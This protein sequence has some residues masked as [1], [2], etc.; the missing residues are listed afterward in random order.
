MT[1]K[2]AGFLATLLVCFSAWAQPTFT[3]AA[4]DVQLFKPGP[5]VSDVLNLQGSRVAEPFAWQA[6]LFIHYARNPLI[7]RNPVTNAPVSRLVGSQTAFDL[8][9]SVG[10]AKNFELG[11]HLPLTLQGSEPAPFLGAAYQ[12]GVSRFGLGDAR[13]TPKYKFLQREEL[14]LAVAL[15]IVIPTGNSSAFLGGGGLG[16][17]PRLI[18]DYALP[19]DFRFLANVG[20]NLRAAHQ[21]LNLRV[22][23]EFAFGVGAE[24]PIKIEGRDF[25][26]LSTLN[27]AVGLP[28]SGGE[29]VPVELLLAG[30]Y[31]IMPN[32]ALTL[33]AGRG[34]TSGYGTPDFRILGGVM[35]TETKKQVVVV[36]DPDPVPEPVKPAC[37]FGPEDLDGCKDEDAC[38]DPDNDADGIVDATDV[39]PDDAETKNNFRDTDGCPDELPPEIA[40]LPRASAA[41]DQDGD[42]I[43]DIEDRCATAAEDKDGFE[44]TDGCP[45]L[46]NDRDGIEDGTDR[47]A[48]EAETIN[49]VTD[50]DGCPDK[51]RSKV[52]VRGEKIVILEKVYF[53]TGKDAIL[54]RSFNVLKQVAAVLKANPH[55][56]HVRIEGHTDDQGNDGANLDLSQRRANSVVAFVVKEGVDPVRLKAV[57]YG[58]TLP[59]DDNKNAK[60][61]ENNRRVEFTIVNDEPAPTEQKPEQKPDAGTDADPKSEGTP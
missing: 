1:S 27:G 26:V 6:G 16:V 39:C 21:L 55:I 56:Q 10:L 19:N 40:P 57:G 38:G 36:K 18:A 30:R 7:I 43:F 12:N 2:R 33:G 22:G 14:G 52:V 17:Q 48:L 5:G 58:E 23:N 24:V 51:G 4:I 60:G 44:D 41:T 28:S 42:G 13:L 35:W 45:E 53:A 34:L 3:S 54:L 32:L 25:A 49:G 46:D 11:L 9:G 20:V 29:E 50:D 31:R 8:L 15:P 47:C 59:V 61:R 37:R